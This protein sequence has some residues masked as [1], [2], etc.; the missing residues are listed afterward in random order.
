MSRNR[1]SLANRENA[2]LETYNRI[3]AVIGKANYLQQTEWPSN[4]ADL[5]ITDLETE[6]SSIA[7]EKK[8]KIRALFDNGR[9]HLETLLNQ[10]THIINGDNVV[11]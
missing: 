9:V 3:K 1:E 8:S 7:D 10:T 2:E 4:V 6:F 11:V 5:F